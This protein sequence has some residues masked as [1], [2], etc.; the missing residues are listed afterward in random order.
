MSD[1]PTILVFA[2]SA[3]GAS[4][5]KKLARVMADEVNKAGGAATLLDMAD[6]VLPLYDGDLYDADGL[7][8]V[9]TKLKKM[10]SE[11]DGLLI[12]SPEYNGSV[13]PMLK[14][15]IDWVTRPAEEAAPMLATKGKVAGI[16]SAS[17]GALGGLRGLFQ[18]R[19][20]LVNIGCYV[21]PQ[22]HAMKGSLLLDDGGMEDEAVR[23]MLAAVAEAT[24][25]LAG[26]LKS[27]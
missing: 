11:A 10:I 17:P 16:V 20:I 22:Q 1:K 6:H 12:A 27:V 15:V 5:N 9:A 8:D 14:N 4:L 25:K 3:R 21:V 23:P 7:G 19:Q 26:A 24:V 2:G 18:L 13:S